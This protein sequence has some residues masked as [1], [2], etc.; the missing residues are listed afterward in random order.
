MSFSAC[1]VHTTK[2]FYCM[3]GKTEH[4]PMVMLAIPRVCGRWREE[5]RCKTFPSGSEDPKRPSALTPSFA[6]IAVDPL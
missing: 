4:I 5:A 6:E 1:R 2:P 3:P